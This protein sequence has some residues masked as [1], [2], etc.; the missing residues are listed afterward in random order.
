MLTD[1]T[2]SPGEALTEFTVISFFDVT[3]R[4]HSALVIKSIWMV[5]QMFHILMC[6]IK[7]LNNYH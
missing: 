2:I 7:S 4:D 3:N 6:V 1:A 5:F